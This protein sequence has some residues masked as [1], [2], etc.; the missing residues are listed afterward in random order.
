MAD[1]ESYGFYCLRICDFVTVEVS[2]PRLKFK[3]RSNELFVV[4][5]VRLAQPETGLTY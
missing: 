3:N 5:V 4:S 2:S 1:F